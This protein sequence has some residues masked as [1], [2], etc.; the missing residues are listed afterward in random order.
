MTKCTLKQMHSSAVEIIS[1]LSNLEE[2]VNDEQNVNE[3]CKLNNIPDDKM[4]ELR[5]MSDHLRKF[6]SRFDELQCYGMTDDDEEDGR[7]VQKIVRTK[8]RREE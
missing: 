7:H 4:T 2:C 8:P 3:I 1:A 6:A 5:N